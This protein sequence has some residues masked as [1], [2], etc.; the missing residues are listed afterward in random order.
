MTWDGPWDPQAWDGPWDDPAGDAPPVIANPA[1]SA[2]LVSIPGFS[3]LLA[4]VAGLRASLDITPRFSGHMNIEPI[5]RGDDASFT[6]TVFD[7]A[8]A[9]TSITGDAI[10]VEV[11]VSQNGPD[12]ALIRKTVGDGVTLLAQAGATLG[13][14]TVAFLGT[15]TDLT[16]GS[17]WLDVVHVRAGVRTHVIGPV[18]LP[19]LNVVNRR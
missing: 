4:K 13:Q 8:G 1:A 15:D 11:K 2:T 6:L 3:G 5:Y 12:P 10:E 16:P 17:Y 19:I 14:A 7:A 9:P 18:Y